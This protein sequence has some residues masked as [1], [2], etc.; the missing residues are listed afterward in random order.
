MEVTPAVPEESRADH[1]V[2]G[3]GAP[4]AAGETAGGGRA[5]PAVDAA[6]EEWTAK[7]FMEFRPGCRGF[8]L[9]TQGEFNLFPGRP[10]TMTLWMKPGCTVDHVKACIAYRLKVPVAHFCVLNIYTHEWL[11][12]EKVLLNLEGRALWTDNADMLD[13][14]LWVTVAPA[15][16]PTWRPCPPGTS[17]P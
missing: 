5:P 14:P 1:P 13:E 7:C 4:A 16:P 17:P 15:W 3:G 9:L 12:R 2:S 8:V 10:R 6:P 11:P